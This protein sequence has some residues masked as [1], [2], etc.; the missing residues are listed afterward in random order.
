[1]EYPILRWDAVINGG[2]NR[3]PMIYIKPD[4]D[5]LEFAKANSFQVFVEVSNTGT[6]Y[7][8][9]LIPGTVNKSYNAPNPRPN[10]FDQTGNYVIVLNAN[11]AGYPHPKSLGKATFKGL[12]TTVASQKQRL[13]FR[14][15]QVTEGKILVIS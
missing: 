4:L 8:G 12:K 10:Y 7:D 1:M 13:L 9:V 2:V 15:N 6:I 5:F 11:W 3:S 14:L